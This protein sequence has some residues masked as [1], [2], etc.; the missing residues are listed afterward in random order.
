MPKGSK[1]LTEFARDRRAS[2]AI[3]FAL[4]AFML[5]GAIG[6]GIDYARALGVRQKLQNMVDNALLAAAP[7]AI[8]GESAVSSALSQFLAV[9]WPNGYNGAGSLKVDQV[10]S[11]NNTV[12]TTVSIDV[13]TMF[14]QVVGIANVNVAV[15]AEAM[16]G[17]GD[18]EIALVLD[19]TGS[20]AGAKL[21]ALK[22]AAKSLIDIVYTHPKSDQHVRVGLVPFSQY[23]N[24]GTDN[25]NAS[26]MDVP[27]DSSSTQEVCW[28]DYPVTGKS[29]CRIET[30]TYSNDGVPTTYEAEVCDYTYGT[31]TKM[32]QNQTVA[33]TWN[34]CVGSRSYPLNVRDEQYS[35]RIPGVMNATC[36]ATITPLTN[37]SSRM[38]NVIDAMVATG[39]TYI[40][41][42]LMWGWRL[43][44]P[45]A[46]FEEAGSYTA[47]GSPKR[48][49]KILVLMTDG[50]N[51]LSPTY[52][53]HDGTDAA[54]ANSLTLEACTQI[55][56][57]GIEI[58]AIAFDVTDTTIRNTLTT[59]ASSPV[60]YFEAVTE[61][62]LR[63][64]FES[65]AQGVVALRLS[66]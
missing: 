31:P 35:S 28:D 27:L 8:E 37:D 48:L 36:T 55:K 44:S 62:Q 50:A 53:A 47:K 66:R 54:L 33:T 19:N 38:R 43:L 14:M 4:S 11:A 64:A 16:V 34:G 3:V 57:A 23:V 45:G 25:R 21:D 10:K 60:N 5:I 41:E 51:T 7:R 63:A 18:A 17:D 52:P 26:W 40:P 56:A 65:I 20:M 22:T 24:V 58:F 15:D 2:V 32:C 12:S 9:Q 46:P 30:F 59:C 49:R 29:N 39:N 13:P 61:A 42:G 1:L 6:M